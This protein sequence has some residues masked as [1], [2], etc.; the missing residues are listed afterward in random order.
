[1]AFWRFSFNIPWLELVQKMLFPRL[2]TL[3]MPGT[4]IM[5]AANKLTSF[6]PQPK[7]RPRL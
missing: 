3:Q 1:M 6:Q 5:F 7:R 2:S 4:S